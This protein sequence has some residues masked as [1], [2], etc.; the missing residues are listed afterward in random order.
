[1]IIDENELKLER[2]EH[3]VTFEKKILLIKCLSLN[4][5]ALHKHISSVH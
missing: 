5:Q 2:E 3:N 4:S 1:M